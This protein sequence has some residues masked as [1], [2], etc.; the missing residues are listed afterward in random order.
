MS[1]ALDEQIVRLYSCVLDFEDVTQI[2]SRVIISSPPHVT[3]YHNDDG[4]RAFTL[5]E[6][7]KRSRCPWTN[8]MYV[9]VPALDSGRVSGVQFSMR[10]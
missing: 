9:C 6:S 5:V 2:Q 7:M 4:R 1:F 10:S 8:R 3:I